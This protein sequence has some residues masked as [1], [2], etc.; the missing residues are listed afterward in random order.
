M[1]PNRVYLL[2][3]FDGVSSI[4]TLCIVVDVNLLTTEDDLDSP[5]AKLEFKAILPIGMRHMKVLN[6]E[7]IGGVYD[8]NAEKVPP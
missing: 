8:V 6:V 1:S 3:I 7:E 5:E 4:I 2:S